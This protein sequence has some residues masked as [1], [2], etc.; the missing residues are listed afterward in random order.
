MTMEPLNRASRFTDMQTFHS[1]FEDV[2]AVRASFLRRIG[3]LAF[4]LLGCLSSPASAQDDSFG[5][6]KVQYMK[7]TWYFLQSDHFDVYFAD[8]GK[9][10]AE[11]TAA[12]AESAYASIS[13]S[14]RYQIVNRIPIIVYN[15]HNAFQQTNV[16][17]RV[18]RGRDRRRY[19]AV[20][21]PHRA[22]VR[23]G[24]QEIPARDPPRACARGD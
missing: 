7:F 11:F 4:V 15:S 16:V 24:L 22:S 6:N 14:F 3:V 17:E 10:L 2:M 5:Q 23:G 20:Q 12:A 21:E 9:P 8:E 13:K 18:P 19:G 1:I